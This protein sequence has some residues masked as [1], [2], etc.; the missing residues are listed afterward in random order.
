MSLIVES[1]KTVN[2]K[3]RIEENT[4]GGKK[5]VFNADKQA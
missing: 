5:Y 3:A 4:E 1:I 2:T